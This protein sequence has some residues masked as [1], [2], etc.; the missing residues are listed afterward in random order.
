MLERM[1]ELIDEWEEVITHRPVV[2]E[3]WMAARLVAY[4]RIA[5][6]TTYNDLDSA[7]ALLKSLALSLTPPYDWEDPEEWE[8]FQSEV[9]RELRHLR[10]E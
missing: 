4:L 3:W 10:G 8:H 9:A 1:F 7:R 2:V 5:V 6:D